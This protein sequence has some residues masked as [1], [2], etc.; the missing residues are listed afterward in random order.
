MPERKAL[1]VL[2]V[3][4]DETFRRVFSGTL[5]EEG[6]VVVAAGNG[7]EALEIMNRKVFDLALVDLRMPLMDGLSLLAEIQRRQPGMT[8]VVL[9]GFGTVP[10]AVEAMRRGAFDMISKSAPPEQVVAT[11]QRAAEARRASRQG[12]MLDDALFEHEAY[13]GMVGRSAAIRR[14]FETIERFQGAGQPV[15]VTGESGTGKELVVRA[16]HGGSPRRAG[17]LLAVNCASL[18]E[19]FVENELFGH[20]RGAFTDA[21]VAKPGLFTLADGGSLHIDEFGELAE[22]AQAALLRVL[23]TGCFRPL[24]ATKETR[25]DVRVLASTNRDIDR[26]VSEGRFRTD[27]FYRLCV[28]RID[29]PALRERREDIPLLINHFL[30]RSENARRL[31][32]RLSQAAVDALCAHDWPGNVRELLNTLERAVLLANGGAVEPGHLGLGSLRVPPKQPQAPPL[33]VDAP[34]GG[35]PTLDAMERAHVQQVLARA[36]HNVSEAARILGVDPTTIR[37]MLRRWGDRSE[38]MD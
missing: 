11:L 23:E 33:P 17:T 2:L 9:T 18:R 15:L 6:F 36:G 12:T 5:G 26:M 25:V 19:N 1:R 30:D 38:Q 20:V 34:N 37:R 4:D 32:A 28:C 3:D 21:V 22:G 29:L 8:P 35:E 27:L 31:G 7:L 16:L 14:V 10:S 24:G 13:F